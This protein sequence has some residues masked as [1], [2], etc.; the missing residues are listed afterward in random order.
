MNDINVFMTRIIGN[1]HRLTP[2]HAFIVNSHEVDPIIAYDQVRYHGAI[3]FINHI[4]GPSTIKEAQDLDLP[5][6]IS[7]IKPLHRHPPNGTH[8]A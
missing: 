3:L 5:L 4:L 7:D 8:L 2:A 1:L 6:Q